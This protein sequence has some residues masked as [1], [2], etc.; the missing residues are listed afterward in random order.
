MSASTAAREQIGE[1]LRRLRLQAG[2]SQRDLSQPG[3]SY[4]YIS[5]IEAGTRTPSAKA[6][7]ALAGKLGV[8]A[9]F[10]A[11]GREQSRCPYCGRNT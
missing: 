10:L 1:R 3:V 2:L 6:L 4:A 9:L 5:R 11:T 7:Q 8:T